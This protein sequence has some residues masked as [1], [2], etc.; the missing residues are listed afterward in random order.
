MKKMRRQRFRVR[1]ISNRE[2]DFES[3]YESNVRTV[4]GYQILREA[5]TI[6]EIEHK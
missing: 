4:G 2:F 5:G 1:S 6:I 3:D